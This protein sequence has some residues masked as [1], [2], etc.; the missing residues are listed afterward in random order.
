M[1]A[2]TDNHEQSGKAG[3]NSS[4]LATKMMRQSSLPVMILVHKMVSGSKCY[5]PGIV[6][7]S[8]DRDGS[9]TPDIR[10]TQLI[11][12]QLQ[13]ICGK[14]VVIPQDLVVRRAAGSL[15]RTDEQSA[16]EHQQNQ[17]SYLKTGPSVSALKSKCQTGTEHTLL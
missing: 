5:Q 17:R 13:F 11:C 3:C 7:R 12:Q 2:H 4:Y 16:G 14:A 1:Q 15:W 10:V 8:W 6:R 9:R